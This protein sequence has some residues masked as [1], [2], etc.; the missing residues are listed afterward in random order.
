MFRSLL[1]L[2]F[3][4]FPSNSY[5]GGV[6]ESLGSGGRFYKT[7]P[8]PYACHRPEGLLTVKN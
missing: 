2:Y 5:G 6:A 1:S 4:A 3:Y 7:L 8:L